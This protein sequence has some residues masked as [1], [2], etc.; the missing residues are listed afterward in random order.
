MDEKTQEP[1]PD[2]PHN[3]VVTGPIKPQWRKPH[4]PA[5][6]FEEYHYYAEKT[7]EEEKGFESPSLNWR[8][9]VLRKKPSNDVSD[10]NHEAAAQK[11]ANTSDKYGISDEE[12]TNAS[13]AFRTASWGACESFPDFSSS[14]IISSF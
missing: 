4:D 9:I 10:D 3:G 7:R 5:V 8:E 12:W 6:T 2:S 14:A 13:R 11:V 1:S